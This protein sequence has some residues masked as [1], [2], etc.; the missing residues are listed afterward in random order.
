MSERFA[1]PIHEAHKEA[2]NKHRNVGR[3]YYKLFKRDDRRGKTLKVRKEAD[4]FLHQ[5]ANSR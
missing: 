3:M 4:E 5:C 1:D 2:G